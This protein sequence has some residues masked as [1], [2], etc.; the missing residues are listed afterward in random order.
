MI[1]LLN[2][3]AFTEDA[4]PDV[5]QIF[6]PGGEPWDLWRSNLSDSFRNE[7]ELIQCLAYIFIRL[8]TLEI[9]EEVH[10]P[11]VVLDELGWARGDTR[12]VYLVGGQDVQS[13]VE[14]AGRL[15]QR[16][17]HT[18][19]ILHLPLLW[20]LINVRRHVGLQLLATTVLLDLCL[21][22]ETAV[23]RLEVASLEWQKRCLWHS[24]LAECHLLLLDK[25]GESLA[26]HRFK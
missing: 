26:N 1:S 24:C 9:D 11:P 12:H 5:V 7:T 19:P 10:L 3:I 15:A 4:S 8:V 23:L 2:T 6:N 13:L 25:R 21:S 22:S 17:K 20:I 16:H 18:R 14:H